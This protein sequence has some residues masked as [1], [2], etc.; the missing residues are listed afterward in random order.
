VLNGNYPLL[1]A[2]MFVGA[3]DLGILRVALSS[4]V[5]I[6]LPSSVANIAVGPLVARLHHDRN[7]TGMADTISH[8]TIACFAA[9]SAAFLI[10]LAAGRPLLSLLFGQDFVGAYI[11]LLTLGAA[12]VIV[13][14]FGI[15]G[16][17]LN[18]TGGER[19]VLRAIVWAVPLGL[20]TTVPLTALFGINGA[21]IG[22]LCMVV[23]WHWYVLVRNR[24]AAA[25]PLSLF[26]AIRH[27]RFQQAQTGIQP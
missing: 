17:Y 13:S 11:P 15:T 2:G 14:A 12:Q 20:L 7:V 21:T 8:T 25:A 10:I 26:A 4:A 3:V 27:I 6:A 24:G 16:T 22:N 19:L 1:I 5:L 9:T 23:I 18:L